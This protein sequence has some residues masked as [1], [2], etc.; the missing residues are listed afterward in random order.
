MNTDIGTS[1]SGIGAKFNQLVHRF[2]L[3]VIFIILALGL[4][5]SI[6]LL[7]NVII[8][9]DQPDGYVSNINTITF[10]QAT[11]DKL[12]NLSQDDKINTSNHDRLTPFD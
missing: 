2:G 1:L 7:N 4:A 9:V 10:D 5:A 3:V 8:R 11:I 6:F 12:K